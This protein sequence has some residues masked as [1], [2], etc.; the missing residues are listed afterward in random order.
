[1]CFCPFLKSNFETTVKLGYN[2]LGYNELPVIVNKFKHLV[3]FSIFYLT[4]LSVIKN[5]IPAI[6]NNFFRFF[7]KLLFNAQFFGNF[8]L[9]LLEIDFY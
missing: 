7:D 1:M 5:Q 9:F 6:T 2:E 8:F 3:W 4:A